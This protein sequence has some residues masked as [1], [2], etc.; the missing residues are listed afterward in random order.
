MR[1]FFISWNKRNFWV[2]HGPHWLTI[3][4]TY[5]QAQHSTQNTFVPGFEF[6]GRVREVLRDWTS[7]YPVVS[8]NCAILEFLCNVHVPPVFM[9][10][11]MLNQVK[12]HISQLVIWHHVWPWLGPKCVLPDSLSTKYY[13]LHSSTWAI[14]VIGAPSAWRAQGPKHVKTALAIDLY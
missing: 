12:P 9:H 1:Y 7:M 11:G 13:G 8:P 4:N 3:H 5:T 6:S 2:T 10:F 14:G